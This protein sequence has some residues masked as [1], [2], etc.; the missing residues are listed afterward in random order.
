M[1]NQRIQQLINK[2]LSGRASAEEQQELDDWYAAQ[3]TGNGLTSDLDEQH[4]SAMGE[5]LFESIHQ[6]IQ[7]E[8]TSS[9]TNYRK[10][11]MAAAVL[12]V[13]AAGAL[14]FSVNKRAYAPPALTSVWKEERSYHEIRKIRLPDSSF[15]WLNAGSIIRY[16]SNFV[17]GKRAF[18]MQGEAFFDV[19][20]REGEPFEV[21][22]GKITTRVLGTAFNIDA[23]SPEEAI[24]VTV[25]RGRVA[26]TDSLH[27]SG[28][29]LPDQRILYKSDGTFEK[30]SAMAGNVTAW[31]T[32]QL[33]FRDMPFSGVAK[34]LEKRFGIQLTFK[35]TSIGHCRITASFHQNTPLND[36][37]DMLA[38]A[39]GS[40]I[41]FARPA[42]TYFI[43][44]KK[45]CK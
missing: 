18:W 25:K 40:T 42:N 30:D 35:D 33:V 3:E 28:I 12:L 20:H 5:Q 14:Y 21:H 45:S 10:W 19:A 44:G 4:K 39:N 34:R 37:L 6:R 41:E 7:Y 38:L 2:V 29:L 26:V 11:V 32:G 36:I 24:A 23:Y 17:S 8:Q 31:T 1:E 43:S 13:L 22:T 9:A 15:V 16:D 27:N